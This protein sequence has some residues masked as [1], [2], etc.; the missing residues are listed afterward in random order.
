MFTDCSLIPS[1][2]SLVPAGTP[3]YAKIPVREHSP[4]Q[5][6]VVKRRRPTL[7]ASW[8]LERQPNTNKSNCHK[9]QTKQVISLLPVFEQIKEHPDIP[10][11]FHIVS[12]KRTIE[13]V[14]LGQRKRT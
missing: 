13:Y 6:T 12:T 5:I 10:G 1:G 4:R 9:N 7:P 11:F 14:G 8:S 3:G 2:D